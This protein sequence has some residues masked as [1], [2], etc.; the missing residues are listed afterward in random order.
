MHFAV[1]HASS[2]D[3]LFLFT[4]RISLTASHCVY[5]RKKSYSSERNFRCIYLHYN[6]IILAPAPLA[7]DDFL[8]TETGGSG[9]KDIGLR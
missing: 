1:I 3:L 7:D 5:V 9:Y 2:P 8:A 4:F 6:R